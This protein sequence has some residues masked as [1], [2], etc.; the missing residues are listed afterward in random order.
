MKRMLARSFRDL[1]EC[2]YYLIL[3][4]DLGYGETPI[5]TSQLEEVS[6]IL[7]SF[8][9]KVES[10][11]RQWVDASDPLYNESRVRGLKSHQRKLVDGSDPLYTESLLRLKFLTARILDL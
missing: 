3:V 6:K 10:H 2:R 8:A 1:I 5:L 7:D 9:Q 11:P 4:Q